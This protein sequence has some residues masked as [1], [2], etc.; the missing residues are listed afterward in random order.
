MKYANY[1]Y[2]HIT[3]ISYYVQKSFVKQDMGIYI[4]ICLN[5]LSSLFILCKAEDIHPSDN[6]N[7]GKYFF[8][9]SLISS[10]IWYMYTCNYR[11]STLQNFDISIKVNFHR[12]MLYYMHI[13]KIINFKERQVHVW[14]IMNFIFG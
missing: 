3:L 6:Y 12:D 7:A 5:I 9:S 11:N 4:N 8:L 13:L 10:I 14:V 1:I 2:S